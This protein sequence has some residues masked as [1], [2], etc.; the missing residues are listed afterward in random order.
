[1]FTFSEGPATAF[2]W[3]QG[4]H[5]AGNFSTTP[6]ADSAPAAPNPASRINKGS[7]STTESGQHLGPVDTH[8]DVPSQA[9]LRQPPTWIA[10]D[11]PAASH[12]P[13][14]SKLSRGLGVSRQNACSPEIAGTPMMSHHYPPPSA[15]MSPSSPTLPN[16]NVQPMRVASAAAAFALED[17]ADCDDTFLQDLDRIEAE[18]LRK[19]AHGDARAIASPPAQRKCLSF[20][21]DR[22]Q[23]NTTPDTVDLT[24]DEASVMRLNSIR[25]APSEVR[26]REALSAQSRAVHDG[27]CGNRCPLT[28]Q[29]SHPTRYPVAG[30]GADSP[31]FCSGVPDSR[32]EV[33]GTSVMARKPGPDPITSSATASAKDARSPA[34]PGSRGRALDPWLSSLLRPHQQEGV[35]FLL[36]ALVDGCRSHPAR[37]R[38]CFGAILADHMGLG[39]TLTSLATLYSMLQTGL[40]G[41]R[42]GRKAVLIAPPSL[43]GQWSNEIKKFFNARLPHLVASNGLNGRKAIHALQDFKSSKSVLLLTSYDFAIRDEAIELLAALPLELLIFDEGQRLK[44]PK[45]K[46]YVLLNGLRCKR[47]LVLTGTPLQNNLWEFFALVTFVGA[48]TF[49]GCRPQFANTYVKP[50][51]RAQTDKASRTDKDFA[52]RRLAELRS[53]LAPIMLRRGA[54]ENRGSLPPLIQLAICCNL[55]KVQTDLYSFFMSMR[56][57]LEVNVAR[58]GGRSRSDASFAAIKLL[59]KVCAH[60]FSVYFEHNDLVAQQAKTTSA[61]RATSTS[62]RIG[63]ESDDESDGGTNEIISAD[64]KCAQA[65][66]PSVGVAWPGGFDP[67]DLTNLWEW[68]GKMLV[69]REILLSCRAHGEKVVVASSFTTVLDLLEDMCMQMRWQS[70]RLDGKVLPAK[71]TEMVDEFNHPSSRTFVFLLSTKAGGSGLNLVGASRLVL[72]EPDW[73]PATDKQVCGRVWRPGQMAK[74]V[75]TYRLLSACTLEERIYSR[76]LKKI[77]VEYGMLNDANSSLC[78]LAEHAAIGGCSYFDELFEPSASVWSDVFE[79]MGD[80]QTKSVEDLPDA[81]LE[82]A[83]GL[84][85]GRWIS[86]IH[87]ISE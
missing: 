68:S 86:H 9:I 13:P 70:V 31:V 82:G 63:L 37:D 33:P 21:D 57:V 36:K 78:P 73:N 14:P 60:P 65:Q 55:T 76:Q 58:R 32:S 26:T 75:H 3:M 87:K 48:G 84:D 22:A 17:L 42:S 41:G 6:P 80:T 29:C 18:A 62:R 83:V 72:M 10:P 39:K 46:A 81:L 53:C 12:R 52:D 11:Q 56:T 50:I 74:A 61:T 77:E 30:T 44:N 23:R 49:V 47:R 28:P 51:E 69:L 40:V 45:A 67:Q 2:S 64:T 54:E 5:T 27:S 15:Y 59:Q 38:T 7:G 66:G 1:M 8:C 25:F 16:E 34:C 19:R 71:R 85:S 79:Q 24:R 20:A 4:V 43:L 35:S